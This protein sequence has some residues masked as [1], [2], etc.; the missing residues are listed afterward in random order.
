MDYRS[1]GDLRSP[2]LFYIQPIV[3]LYDT[4]F[5][6]IRV[7]MNES[8]LFFPSIAIRNNMNEAL[9]LRRVLTRVNT[10]KMLGCRFSSHLFI[11]IYY[12]YWIKGT[13]IAMIEV[14]RCYV[15]GK[16]RFW[17]LFRAVKFWRRSII[18][19]PRNIIFNSAT[20]RT[21]L[22]G[23]LAFPSDWK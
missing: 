13:I 8:S 18:R 1:I 11:I 3:Y 21:N 7:S 10:C 14:F 17:D 23:V 16:Q 4:G 15:S 5:C 2:R 9:F 19:S 6:S 12:Y 20:L 22:T